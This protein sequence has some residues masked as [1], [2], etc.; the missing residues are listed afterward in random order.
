MKM[1]KA[2]AGDIIVMLE[3]NSDIVVG[4]ILK[5]DFRQS[6]VGTFR[7]IDDYLFAS[8]EN[9][10]TEGMYDGEYEILEKVNRRHFNK[11]LD[12]FLSDSNDVLLSRFNGE[13]KKDEF[14]KFM[15]LVRDLCS[16]G[17]GR[18]GEN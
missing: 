13:N 11:E 5:V 10:E 7:D 6:D 1:D 14:Y 16:Q 8:N 17:G 9:Y 15:E 18:N 2:Y 12:D 3:N 4:A